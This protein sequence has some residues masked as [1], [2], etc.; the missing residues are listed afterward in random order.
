MSSVAQPATRPSAPASTR[1]SAPRALSMLPNSLA[2]IAAKVATLGLGFLFWLLAARLFS[3]RDVG[4]AAGVVAAVMLCTQ[5]AL[6]GA[7][8]AVISLYPEH[9]DS[10]RRLLHTGINLVVV[11]GA[12]FGLAFVAL[13]V[14]AFP[15]LGVVGSSAWYTILFASM[16]IFGTLAILLDQ[17]STTLRRGDE[18]FGRG[19]LNGVLSLAC[20]AVL[21]VMAR[22]A[23]SMAI[24]AC[25]VIGGA[26]ACALG[27]LQLWRG[28]A[29]YRWRAQLDFGL[30]RRLVIVGL[31]N[32]LLTLADRAPGLILPVIVTELLSPTMNAFWYA[33]WMMAWL[34]FV[35][36]VQV[37]MTLFSEASHRP[38][39]IDQLVRHG[40]RVGLGIGA[41]AAVG[42][43]A[44]ASVALSLMGPR[45]ASGGTDALRVLVW[46]V[47][48]AAVIQVYYARSR[49]VRRLWEA[50]A[51]AMVSGTLTVAAAATAGA[52]W[53]LTA[54]ALA[55]LGVQS[56][57]AVWAVWRLQAFKGNRV[58]GGAGT[59]HRFPAAVRERV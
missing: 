51:A 6:L 23:N 27:G 35:I 3:P 38:Q 32:H 39:A 4:L 30:A 2:L 12:V 47:V 36:P 29:R 44:L 20:L 41:A 58:R 33:V 1:A 57:A 22:S 45:Y 14:G 16:S 42:M 10:P 17:I 13:A 11:S 56:L 54:M 15:K 26:A 9:A 46:G 19:V 53:G 7:G 52:E 59:G 49:A 8:A 28:V 43:A 40:L 50:I 55:W 5:F 34:V 48:P 24:F 25:W 37:G 21:G 31:P 18:A